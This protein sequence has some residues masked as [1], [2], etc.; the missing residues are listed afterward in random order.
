MKNNLVNIN[1]VS[2]NIYHIV[3]D[4]PEKLNALNN[5]MSNSISSFLKSNSFH[6]NDI[7]IFKSNSPK[8]FCAGGDL[9]EGY[10][11]L[12]NKQFQEAHNQWDDEYNLY[13][14]LN[15]VSDRIMS[16]WNG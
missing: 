2:N 4:R 5:N 13:K 7:L 3:L 15:K 8:A 6:K 10:N 16:I 9:V 14:E 1:Q 11:W 12:K